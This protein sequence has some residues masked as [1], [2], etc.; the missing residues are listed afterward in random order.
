MKKIKF[1]IGLIVLTIVGLGIYSC[2][3]GEDLNTEEVQRKEAVANFEN[4]IKAKSDEIQNLVKELN[5]ARTQAFQKGVVDKNLENEQEEKAKQT[6]LPLLQDSKK[7]LLEYGID[8]AF[9][10][11][12]FGDENHPAILNMGLIYLTVAKNNSVKYSEANVFSGAISFT[13]Q[14]ILSDNSESDW[15]EIKN[16]LQ[17]ALGIAD[18]GY[19][20]K[21][22]AQL[23]AATTAKQVAML[24]LKRYAGWATLGF[25]VYDFVNCM[26]YLSRE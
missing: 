20:I 15:G 12:E 25:L 9:L 11:E 6:L 16:C 4:S 23:A 18:I 5:T 22:T 10:K 13:R 3:K 7:L 14:L 2:Q 26:G 24:V 19:I 8:D 21:N 1:L 17:V